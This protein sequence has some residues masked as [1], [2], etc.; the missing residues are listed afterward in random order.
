MKTKKQKRIIKH[1]RRFCRTRRGGH[2]TN[3]IVRYGQTQLAGQELTRQE[4]QIQPSV[5]F[6]YVPGKLYT[7]IMWDPD[8][9]QQ[10]Q[11]G[12]VHWIVTNIQSPKD[13]A[14][15]ALL[16]YK[17]P[18]PPFGTHR[19]YFGLFEQTSG[20]VSISAPPNT[21]F[22]IEQ[23]TKVNKLKEVAK[24]FMKVSKVS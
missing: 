4:T 18:S 7:L 13:I 20:H 24:L 22:S 10:I 1:K 9:P 11:P 6:S 17:G 21:K 12:F 23:F 15:N 5:K 16:P 14:S 19:Y 2:V 3:L 8:V